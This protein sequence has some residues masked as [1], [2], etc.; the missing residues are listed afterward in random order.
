MTDTFEVP[1]VADIENSVRLDLDLGLEPTFGDLLDALTQ[2][3]IIHH[4]IERV[5]PTTVRQIRTTID[6]LSANLIRAYLRGPACFVAIPLRPRD[7]TSSRYRNRG[8]G[9]D[10]LVKVIEFLLR[11]DEPYLTLEPAINSYRVTRIRATFPFVVLLG[12]GEDEN[13]RTRGASEG[14]QPNNNPNN[15]LSSITGRISLSYQS[16]VHTGS[17]DCIRLKGPKVKDEERPELP[18][19]AHLIPYEDT[20]ETNGMRDRLTLWN[21]SIRSHLLDLFVHDAE[22]ENIF[23]KKKRRI[24]LTRTRLHRVFNN[25]SF[26]EGGRFYGGWWQG[27]PKRYRK[28]ITIDNSPTRELDY[29]GLHPVMLYTNMGLSFPTEPYSIEGIDPSF[30]GLIKTTFNS[31]INAPD[32][33]ISGPTPW[34]QEEDPLPEGWTFEQIKQAIVERHLPIADYFYSGEGLKLQRI[35]SNI[36]ADV[37]AEM[38]SRGKPVLPVHD[39]F[40]VYRGYYK[41]LREVMF[42]AY[43]RHVDSEIGIKVVESFADMLL[44]EHGPIG[45]EDDLDQFIDIEWEA[46]KLKP[47]YAGYRHRLDDF[48]SRLSPERAHDLTG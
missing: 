12:G 13:Y 21:T 17:G 32:R 22:F 29:S 45:P 14:V 24:D 3:T 18:A 16:V 1:L 43:K 41:M 11:R 7:Y 15:N 40:I 28:F 27:V 38:M 25:S 23:D 31:L 20:A 46:E 37:M 10:N 9:Y 6:C 34:E 30:R 36:A 44:P 26:N 33:R 5:R 2:E 8:I 19:K 47:G 39:S 48:A 4:E 35:D 42:D